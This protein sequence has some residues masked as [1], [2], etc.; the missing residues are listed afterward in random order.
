[1]SAIHIPRVQA[2]SV[3]QVLSSGRTTPCLLLCKNESGSD[4]EVVI[5]WRGALETK[6]KGLI[7]ELL[8]SL[9]ADD[10]GLPV[11]KPFLVEVEAGCIVGEGKP[12]LATIARDSVGLNFGSE[13]LPPGV[14]TWPKDKPIPVLLRSLAAEVFAF[15]LLIQNPRSASCG[16][17]LKGLQNA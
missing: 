17:R 3:L 12:K 10:L 1:M 5:K 4:D 16:R 11:A 2:A 15:D 9:L 8:A 14:G 13:K 6:A 7:A